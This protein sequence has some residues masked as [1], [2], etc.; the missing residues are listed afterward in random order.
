MQIGMYFFVFVDLQA[1]NFN[2]CQDYL[3]T[4]REPL[5]VASDSGCSQ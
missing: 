5:F 2:I 3:L 4:D 1:T